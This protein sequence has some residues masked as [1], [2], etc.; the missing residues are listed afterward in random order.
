[1]VIQRL[2]LYAR[3]LTSLLEGGRQVVSS[4]DIAMAAGHTAAQ[5]RRDLSYFGGFGKQGKGYDAQYLLS[6][7]KAILHIN[8][9]WR[10]VLV[11]AGPLGQ[12]IARNNRF[13]QNGFHISWVYDHNAERI[14]TTLDG[15]T[16]EHVGDMRK[17]I[18]EE[19]V[20][21]AILAVP[22]QAAQSV[23]ETLVDAGIRA[24]LNYS[25]TSIQVPEW[26][27]VY[28]ID[29]V[30]ALQS[31]TYYLTTDEGETRTRLSS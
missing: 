27:H 20:K 10:V 18:I 31:L 7:I 30:T 16:V 24:I 6:R 17:R 9:Q 28:N 14:G 12:A 1:M 13:A 22:H 26:V 2:P 19:D 23:T 11:G 21:I 4:Q 25:P 5:V 15:L 3:A 8:E 29:P